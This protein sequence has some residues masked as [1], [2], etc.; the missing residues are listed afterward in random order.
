[1]K[2]LLILVCAAALALGAGS[3]PRL[4]Y[5]EKY[6]ALA[7]SE[8]QR[9]GVPASITLAQALVESGAGQSPLAVYANNHFGIKCHNDWKGKTMAVDDDA[10][11]ECFRVYDADIDSFHD[12]SDFLR[13]RDRYKFL[14]DFPVTDY[15][16]WANGL[17]KAGYATDP[18]YPAKLIKLI[19]DY[20][21][22]RFDKAKQ[23]D[24][25]PGGKY[26]NLT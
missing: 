11:G 10:K 8:M 1:M 3:N 16:A 9:A 4:S 22:G 12:H 26:A 20:D 14:F 24:F 5:I 17:K 2:R 6:A 18:A 25:E 23:S 21:L 13:Y 15:K 7:V 19:E